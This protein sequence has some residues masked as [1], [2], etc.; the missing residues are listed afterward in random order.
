MK[1][2][3]LDTFQRVLV[4]SDSVKYYSKLES[5]TVGVPQ[6]SIL[7]PLLFLLYVNDLLNAISDLSKP[8][9]FADDASQIITNPDI[10]RSMLGGYPCHHGMARPR[11]ADGRDGLQ[12]EVS[13]EYIE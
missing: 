1:S 11:V 9:L 13:C 10:Q 12:L 4:V 6:G 5:V 3:L 7:G 2:Y 8:V